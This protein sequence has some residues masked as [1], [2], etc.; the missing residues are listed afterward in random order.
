M[1]IEG[2]VALVTGAASGIGAALISELTH[3]RARA[4]ILVDRSDHVHDLARAINEK[5][6]RE[7][8]EAWVGD[9]TDG[10]FRQH[11]YD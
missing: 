1:L 10:D 4:I 7:V 9:T 5:A 8:A 3:R 2:K 11:V 6:G